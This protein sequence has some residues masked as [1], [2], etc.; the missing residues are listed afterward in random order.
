MSGEPP[1][2]SRERKRRERSERAPVLLVGGAVLA[3][4]E[5]GRILAHRT[6]VPPPIATSGSLV[7]WELH[8]LQPGALGDGLQRLLAEVK[9]TGSPAAAELTLAGKLGA[10]TEPLTISLRVAAHPRRA[11]V[12]LVTVRDMTAYGQRLRHLSETL[13]VLRVERDEWEATARTVAHDVRSSLSALTGFM[14]LALME[15]PALPGEAG[16]HLNRALEIGRRLL[17]LTDLLV[18]NPR[19]RSSRA[20]TVELASLGARLLTALQV[21]HPGLSLRWSVQAAGTTVQANASGVWSLL[22]GLA[23][24]AV[25]YRHPDR[26]LEISL[27]AKEQDGEVRSEV[28]DNGIGIPAG[29]EEAV[30]QAGRRGSNASGVAGSGLGLHSVRRLAEKCR[31]RAWA[32]P[33]ATGARFVVVLPKVADVPE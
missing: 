22:W 17:T 13:D 4:G 23:S 26:E 1:R 8:E 15:A 25:K 21:A 16:E 10:A 24:N 30:F 29:E 2:R 19:R 20:E 11:G 33:L 28:E 14:N 12:F 18:D 6:P 32:E 31:G 5:D 27:R 7:G 3:V 9:G